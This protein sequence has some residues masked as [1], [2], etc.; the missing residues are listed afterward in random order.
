MII[1]EHKTTVDIEHI[2][3]YDERDSYIRNVLQPGIHFTIKARSSAE[4][5]ITYVAPL[6]PQ[7]G[8][9]F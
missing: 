3:E 9:R 7:R 2:V 5:D 1:I 8:K 4:H 6:E